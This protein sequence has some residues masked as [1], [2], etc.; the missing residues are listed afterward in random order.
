METVGSEFAVELAQTSR[1]WRQDLGAL[2][3][4]IANTLWSTSTSRTPRTK[5]PA[6]RLTQN[7]KREAKGILT[8]T[9]LVAIPSRESYLRI[10]KPIRLDTHDPIS[11]ARR[12][13]TQRR[14][15][16]ALKAWNPKNKPNW[17]NEKTYREKIAPRLAEIAVPAIV[18][19]LAVSQP[20]ARDIRCGRC[21][22]H[23]RHWLKCGSPGFAS[24]MCA[25]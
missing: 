14:Q 22:P 16:A 13:K 15:A 8:R 25:L 1:I 23:P 4:W 12:A 17:L 24:K 9:P 10:P 20:Y 7:R 11:Q 21:I 5:A 2:A 3:E 18:S 6:T 19:A